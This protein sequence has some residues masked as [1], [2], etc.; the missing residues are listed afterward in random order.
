MSKKIE[1]LIYFLILIGII[2]VQV[3]SYL[4][5]GQYIKIMSGSSSVVWALITIFC[6]IKIFKRIGEK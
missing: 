4:L 2:F 3:D 1:L 5:D 6:I